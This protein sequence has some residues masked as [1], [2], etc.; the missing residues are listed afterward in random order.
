MPV[1]RTMQP[2]ATMINKAWCN[3]EL[4][5]VSRKDAS[6]ATTVAAKTNSV[7]DVCLTV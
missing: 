3:P 7:A 1:Q 4:P 2:T 6:I 5:T